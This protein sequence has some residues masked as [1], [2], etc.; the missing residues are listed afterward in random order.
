MKL[1]QQKY[2]ES[3]SLNPR[4]LFLAIVGVNILLGLIV[5][6]FP[7]DGISLTA[8]EKIKFVSANDFWH[9]DSSKNTVDLEKV[10]E[11]VNPVAKN[12]QPTPLEDTSSS[13]SIIHRIKAELTSL[14]SFDTINKELRP[15]RQRSIQLPPN[16]PDAL[17]ALLNGLVYESKERVIRIVHYGDSQLEGDRITDYFRNRLQ[18][19]FGGTGPGILLPNEPA[20]SARRSAYVTQSENY[21]K[22]AIYTKGRSVKEGNYGVGAASFLIKGTGSKFLGIDTLEKYVD[23]TGMIQF[24][25]TPRFSNKNT[26]NFIRIKSGSLGYSLT[27]QYST[28]KLIHRVSGPFAVNVSG[29][30]ID[31]SWFVQR[32]KSL[33]QIDTF[34]FEPDKDFRIQYEYGALPTVYGVA[35][36]GEK[37][38]AVDN[39]GMRGSSAVGFNKINKLLYQRQLRDLNV[40]CII[41]QYGVN[42][43]PNVRKDYSYY[44][45]T[46]VKELSSIRKAQP[47]VSILVVG[48]SDM[49]KNIGGQKVSYPNIPLIRDA[50]RE[51]AFETG[52]A[53]WDLYESMGGKNAMPEWVSKGLAQKDYT[54]FSY[55][56]AKYV[57]EML[58]EALLE[59]IQN[60]GYL[61]NGVQ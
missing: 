34:G 33:A 30:R 36:D 18:Q 12:N 1:D 35:L 57:G 3:R 40:K 8:N 11:G 9:T 60:Q 14:S 6:F 43:V 21:Y 17:K 4:D 45:K 41:L 46:L 52:C 38:V 24:R 59:Q 19:L 58:F 28:L 47:N 22:R 5:L 31:T 37:G 16:N 26:A 55:N 48:P 32:I 7:T 20:A 42:V 15:P 51:A 29:S 23:S 56:G 53:F 49:S 50:M 39:F 44:K 25:S 13:D 27:Q 54:H 2:L 10:L 61:T